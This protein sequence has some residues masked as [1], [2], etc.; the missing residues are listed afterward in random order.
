MLYQS[1]DRCGICPGKHD[2][3]VCDSAYRTKDMD[4]ICFV[5]DSQATA[6]MVLGRVVRGEA[7][8]AAGLRHAAEHLD[9]IIGMSGV[10]S[11]LRAI[12]DALDAEGAQNADTH[13]VG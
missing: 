3:K 4:D 10:V 9:I 2:R 11:L 7:N 13:T 1:L 12:A 5:P 8:N 6:D